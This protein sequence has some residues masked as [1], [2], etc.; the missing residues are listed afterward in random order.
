LEVHLLLSTHGMTGEPVA[1]GNLLL[2]LLMGASVEFVPDQIGPPL[3]ARMDVKA[4]MF[5]REGR[6]VFC[7]TDPCVLPLAAVGYVECL[8]EVVEQAEAA[9]APIGAVYVSSAGS[10]GAGLA[11]A[12][13]ALGVTFP[14]INVCPMDWPWDTQESLARIANDAAARLGIDTRLIRD[15]VTVTFDH[16]APGYGKVSP[17]SLEAIGLL[18][19]TEGVLLDPIYSGK[20][21]AGL[22]ADVRAGRLAKD[23]NVVLIHTGGTPALFAHAPE[24]ATA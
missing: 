19:R 1:Q 24:L 6:N 20:A 16:L 5:R 14:V 18:G 21:A 15:D 4:E 3:N 12:A 17:G 13:K 11:L 22:I 7:W 9:S 10:T 2:D 8:V 23:R